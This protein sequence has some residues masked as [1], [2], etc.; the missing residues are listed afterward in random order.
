[1]SSTTTR[2]DG[3]L[4]YLETP[5]SEQLPAIMKVYLD[6]PEY[7]EAVLGTPDFDPADVEMMYEEAISDE[8]RFYFAVRRTDSKAL[9]GT[10]EVE[11]GNDE[12]PAVLRGLVLAQAERGKGFGRAALELVEKFLMDEFA[13][14]LLTADV[15]GGF[16]DGERFLEAMGYRQRRLK[17]GEFRW[18]KRLAPD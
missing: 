15:P 12:L 17:S 14:T 8:N 7:F 3:P 11:S 10:I 4:I 16:D 18:V 5:G 2:I 9:I 13:V 1:M 6:A